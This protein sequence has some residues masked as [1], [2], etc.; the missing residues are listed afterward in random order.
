MA[1][2]GTGTSAD[3]WIV[4]SYSEIKTAIG[5]ASYGGNK[6]SEKFYVTLAND[7]DCNDYD[8][9]FEWETVGVYVN[10]NNY[11]FDLDG[12]TIKNFKVK[13]GNQVFQFGG[14]QPSTIKNG[15]ILNVF[16]GGSKG[17]VS[18]TTGG[19]YYYSQL[20][21]LSISVNTGTGITTDQVFCCGI[22]RCAIYAEGKMNNKDLV[23]IRNEISGTM[24]DSDV[25]SRSRFRGVASPCSGDA[26]FKSA[27]SSCVIDVETDAHYSCYNTYTVNS[28]TVINKSKTPNMTYFQGMIQATSDV[29]GSRIT[30]GDD[31]RSL[32]FE[33][34][35]VSA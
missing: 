31:L 5:G 19:V 34:V 7:I 29:V 3:P 17:F 6:G 30:V 26:L 25:I 1:I 10:N 21:D 28:S 2:T 22:K 35:N 12:H 11:V 27:M 18:D 9:S 15:K 4:H 33:V 13:S 20:V 23:Y 24:E 16:L 32:G 8:V 14:G